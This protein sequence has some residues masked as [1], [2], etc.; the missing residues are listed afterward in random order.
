MRGSRANP[1]ELTL[2][3]SA[4]LAADPAYQAIA[5]GDS[6]SSDSPYDY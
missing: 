6:S 2:R 1:P 4:E 5:G 3:V